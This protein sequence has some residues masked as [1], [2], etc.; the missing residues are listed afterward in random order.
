ML[1]T[2][3]T[4]TSTLEATWGGVQ[5]EMVDMEPVKDCFSH[6]EISTFNAKYNGFRQFDDCTGT[7][8]FTAPAPKYALECF[9]AATGWNWTL[10]DV[11]TIG[12][13]IVN[14]L[15]VYNFRHGLDIKTER[16]SVRYSTPPVDGPAKGVDI[17]A[18]WDFMAKNYYTLM[19]WDPESGK[20]LP[21]TLEKY[22]LQDIVKDL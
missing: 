13:R 22:G 2:C 19:G 12:L 1:D 7:C 9:N 17:M 8:R 11:F 20:P 21:E 10:E 3:F 16:P 18:K 14:L 15:R 5:P 6:E 4:N